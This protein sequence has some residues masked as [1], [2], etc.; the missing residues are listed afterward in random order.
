MAIASSDPAR[1]AGPGAA[2]AATADRARPQLDSDLAG[3]I[4]RAD[5]TGDALDQVEPLLRWELPQARVA[6]AQ[7]RV[8]LARTERASTRP[9]PRPRV[10]HVPG[11]FRPASPRPEQFEARLQHCVQPGDGSSPPAPARTMRRWRTAPA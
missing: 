2:A 6:V 10:R 1:L 11:T 8:R 7:V 5:W 3:L 4:L 9:Q